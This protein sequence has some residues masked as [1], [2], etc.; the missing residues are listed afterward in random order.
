MATPMHN[1]CWTL[2]S[3]WVF[4]VGLGYILAIPCNMGLL[5]FWAALAVDEFVRAAYTCLRWKSNRWSTKIK[6]WQTRMIQCKRAVRFRS[7]LKNKV[8]SSSTDCMTRWY[9]LPDEL[10]YKKSEELIISAPRSL[11]KNA[12]QA[13]AEMW[14]LECSQSKSEK[15]SKKSEGWLSLHFLLANFLRFMAANLSLTQLETWARPR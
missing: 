1:R 13:R 14:I 2:V 10:F 11:S 6:I 3:S 4:S 15:N 7:L 8:K 12:N 9:I 5:G